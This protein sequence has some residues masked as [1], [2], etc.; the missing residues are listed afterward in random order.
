MV[1]RA[2][3]IHSLYQESHADKID[4][5]AAAAGI[6]QDVLIEVNDGESNKQ[7]VADENLIDML[8]HCAALEHV[9]VKGLMIMAPIGD[10]SV[11]RATFKRLRE[12]RDAAQSD[13]AARGI[14]MELHELS[15]GMSNDYSEGIGAGG[16][17]GS[18]RSSHIQCRLCGLARLIDRWTTAT[19]FKIPKFDELKESAGHWR[20]FEPG[21]L[22][23]L[24]RSRFSR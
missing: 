17:H 5:L 22:A 13:L 1:G 20:G 15:M 19:D 6:V 11:A 8:T 10:A 2:C 16:Y 9:R 23:L 24:A 12:L 3:L 4:R 18:H 14:D 21:G 7:G